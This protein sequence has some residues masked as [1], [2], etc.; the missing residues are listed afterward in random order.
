M[1]YLIQ[2]SVASG[3]SDALWLLALA[4][5]LSWPLSKVLLRRF[6]RA[7]AAT[8][9]SGAEIPAAGGI[10]AEV[11]LKGVE[12]GSE[13]MMEFL[14]ASLATRLRDQA[15]ATVAYAAVF[16]V[17]TLIATGGA[18]WSWARAS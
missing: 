9:R 6:H 1:G 12:A 16:T 2:S 8:M 15:L 11:Q 7:A 18:P 13:R 10:T 14:R 3:W 17:G 5:L 4:C